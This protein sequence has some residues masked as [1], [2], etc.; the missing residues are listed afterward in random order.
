[1]SLVA[2]LAAMI[3]GGTLVCFALLLGFRGRLV[4]VAEE[5][6]V[7]LFRATGAILGLSLGAFLFAEL[8]SWPA[9]WNPGATGIAMFQVPASEALRVGIF[10]AYWVSYAILEIWTLDPCRLLD[11][12]GVIADRVAYTAQVRSVTGQVALNAVLFGAVVALG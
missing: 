1:M 7:R 3:H 12:G 9:T 5:H 10:G 11:Q 4:A 8:W 6:V 2:D